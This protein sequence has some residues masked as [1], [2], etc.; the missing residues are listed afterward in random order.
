MVYRFPD[1][2]K[3]FV[4]PQGYKNIYLYFSWFFNIHL[5]ISYFI[6]VNGVYCWKKL[7]RNGSEAKKTGL[8]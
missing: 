4:L 7:Q 8:A 1:M 5:F 6:F 3:N 2:L